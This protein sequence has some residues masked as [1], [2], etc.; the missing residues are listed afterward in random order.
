MDLGLKGQLAIVT[1]ASRGLGRAVATALAGEGVDVVIVARGREAL[2][3]CAAE[4]SLATGVRV[5]PVVGDTGTDDSVRSMVATAVGQ[6]GGVDI[7]ANCAAQ[8][9]P[10]GKRVRS[11]ADIDDDAFF[12]DINVKVMGYLRCIREVVPHMI[13]RGGG[14][15]VNISG[16]NTYLT[17]STIGSMRNAAVVALTANLADELAVHGIAVN[18]VHPWFTRAGGA[19]KIHK[20]QAEQE[21]VTV[22]EVE[23]RLGKR[24]LIGR[25][26]EGYEIANVVA[27]LASPIA[28]AINGDGIRLSGGISGRI[29]Y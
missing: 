21:G 8:Q 15:I 28:V 18:A 7:L 12:P 27:F 26:V 17:G 4:L 23:Q 2:E 5:I 20:M 10:P 14:R 11:L 13:Q 29:Y 16:M 1:G 19:A 9:P 6:L 25:L 22:A 3:E 24:S